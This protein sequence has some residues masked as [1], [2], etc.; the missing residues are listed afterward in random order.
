MWYKLLY[1][2]HLCLANVSADEAHGAMRPI[3]LKNSASA[4]A[5]IGWV[6]IDSTCVLN[7]QVRVT[8]LD[9]NH[10]S[11]LILEDFPMANMKTPHAMMPGREKELRTFRGAGA[12]EGKLNQVC[13]AL[14]QRSISVL[15]LVE[16]LS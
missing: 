8:G 11:T 16:T 13:A 6:Y 7:Y 9:V 1:M 3:L 5:G 14:E 4:A 15:L 2:V 10:E 12:A